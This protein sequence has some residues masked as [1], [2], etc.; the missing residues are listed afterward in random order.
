MAKKPAPK[1]CHKINGPYADLCHLWILRLYKSGLAD[2]GRVNGIV[3]RQLGENADPKKPEQFNRIISDQYMIAEA[4]KPIL[5]GLLKKNLDLLGKHFSIFTIAKEIFA[6]RA[7][8]RINSALEDTLDH[9][10]SGPWTDSKTQQVLSIALNRPMR[11]IELALT[12]NSVLLA[13][14]LI[15]AHP[16]M[17]SDF[18]SKLSVMPGIVSALTRPAN[19]IDELLSFAVHR[20]SAGNLTSG[21]Y[22][23]HAT[24]IKLIKSHLV[25]SLKLR[26]KGVNILLYGNPGVGKTELAKAVANELGL[27]M[28][29]V[30][31]TSRCDSNEDNTHP[32]F[33]AYQMLQRLLNKSKKELILF[34]EIEDVLPKPEIIENKGPGKA[35]FNKLLEE[36]PVPTLWISNHVWQIDPAFMRRFDIVLELR[37]PPRSV[38]KEIL[39]KSLTGL[40]VEKQ[41]IEQKSTQNGIT[42]ALTMR[43][44][45]VVRSTD[46]QDA[47]N[48]QHYFDRLM[49]EHLRS[50]GQKSADAYNVLNEYRLNWLNTSLDI[51]VVTRGLA[52]GRQGKVLLYG[53]PGCGKTAFAYH[54]S[55]TMDCPLMLKRGSDLISKWIGETEANIRDMFLEAA[56]EEAILL[57]D[58]AD[59]FLQDRHGAER[60]WELTQVNELL[61][62]MENFRGVFICATNFIEQLDTAAIRRFSFKISFDYLKAEQLVS[63][64]RESM[65]DFN[66]KETAGMEINDAIDHLMRLDNLTPGDFAA[67]SEQFKIMGQIP[68][69]MDYYMELKQTSQLK[70]GGKSHIGFTA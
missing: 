29:E 26:N 23:H 31:Q 38:R 47:M 49:N 6:F 33:R 4:N 62:Q 32:R 51:N 34:D 50:I 25:E 13:S 40:P 9:A 60:I 69:P 8:Y 45:N 59:S 37:N 1:I 58:E 11:Q 64:F 43:I 42:P 22:P 41:W 67:I 12:K 57:L 15:N 20:V 44:A 19:S 24:D 48:L 35:W 54:L 52:K 21:D 30:T 56:D 61:T 46:T 53:P 55:K 7:I 3:Q 27:R 68:R 5:D 14:G 18:G 16:S 17:T 2:S 39:E 70:T 28:L 65:Q 63:I 66:V 36:N 10:I